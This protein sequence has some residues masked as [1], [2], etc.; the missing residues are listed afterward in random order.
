MGGFTLE[1]LQTTIQETHMYTALA[2]FGYGI[3]RSLRPSKV[4]KM[5]K[6]AA[7]KVASKLPAGKSKD[8]FAGASSKVGEGYR[9]AYGATLGTSTRRKVTSAVIGTSFLKDILDD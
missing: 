2:R 7:D 1:L 6:P 9:K 3:A 4:K 8:L 5:I